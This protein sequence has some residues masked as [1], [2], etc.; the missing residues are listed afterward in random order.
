MGFSHTC[1][2]CGENDAYTSI[3]D[4]EYG[5]REYAVCYDCHPPGCMDDEDADVVRFD[6]TDELLEYIGNNQRCT[7]YDILAAPVFHEIEE[8]DIRRELRLMVRR[9]ELRRLGV[10]HD[11]RYFTAAF[12]DEFN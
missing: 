5:G 3:A 1:A 7:V 4:P 10:K 12:V 2:Y 11:T 8:E 6:L 9:K